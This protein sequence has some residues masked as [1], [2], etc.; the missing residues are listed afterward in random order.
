VR[1]GGGDQPPTRIHRSTYER[2]RARKVAPVEFS[3]R[4]TSILSK[5]IFRNMAFEGPRELTDPKAMRAMAHPVRLALMEALNDAGTLTATEAAERVGESPSNCSF[6]LRQL[7][8]YG[9]VEEADGGTGRQRPWKTVHTGMRFSDVHDD[10]EAARAGGVLA[11]VV[12]ER[13]LERA[14]VGL[15][16][17]H[18]QPLEWRRVSGSDQMTLYVTP[19][20][21]KEIN[22]EILQILFRYR[23]RIEDQ[24]KRPP[25][26][27]KMEHVA[28]YYPVD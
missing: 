8:K 6:H 27:R 15:A 16:Q 9:F 1:V 24:S 11:R 28:F 4:L 5:V 14:R 22:D 26:S 7:A 19:E 25:G 13:W 2:Q 18:L 23:D 17:R 12:Q 10:P 3:Q 20:E 21:M